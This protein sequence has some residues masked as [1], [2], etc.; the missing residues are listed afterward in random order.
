MDVIFLVKELDASLRTGRQLAEYI[1][2]LSFGDLP[3]EVVHQAKRVTLDSLGTILMGLRKDEAQPVKAFLRGLAAKPECTVARAGLKT[4]C[5]WAAFANASYAQV[6]DCNDGHRDS[7]ALG[8]SAHPGRTVIPTA[9]A[10]AEK[11]GSSGKDVVTAMVVGYD[12]ATRIRGIAKRPPSATQSS[13]AVAARLM[14]L[15]Q[16]KA[17]YA[18]SVAAFI[19][20]K[21]FPESLTY[22]TNFLHN[23]YEAKTGI[24]AAQLAADGFN[25]PPM[26]DDR[27]LSTRFRER[28]LGE[29]YEIMDVYIKP[30]PTCRMT[31]GAVEAI[32]ALRQE[33]LTPEQVEEIQVQQLTSGMYITESPVD[34]DSYYKTCQFNL[35][36]IA[37]VA[38]I[39]GKVT[40]Q[41]FT[42]E[43]IA[44]KAV[45]DL[46]KKVKVKPDEDLDAIY[47]DQYRP[48]TVEVKTKKG[49]TIRRTVQNP[50]GD[51][52]NTLSDE[53]LYEKFRLW[54]GPSLTDD[55]AKEIRR[56]VWRLDRL[57]SLSELMELIA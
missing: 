40:E 20:P 19:S 15:G 26:G 34:V 43:R 53:A 44:D 51:P 23:G 31:H 29:R 10:V 36:Y 35:P 3:G 6:H 48:T 9:L 11:L 2:G 52:R 7:A 1:H 28:G 18:L 39:D 16:E 12:V 21:A 47:P 55:Q 45:H 50:Y 24:E 25:G 13:A 30:Y 33:G 5:G 14:G 56:V 42:K 41:Q 54:A 4:E 38:L 57:G 27:K 46:A 32:L 17:Q 49:E 37:A 22:D 8:G